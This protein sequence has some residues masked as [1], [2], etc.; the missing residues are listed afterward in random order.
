MHHGDTEITEKLFPDRLLLETDSLQLNRTLD[1]R[2]APQARSIAMSGK[3]SFYR[4]LRHFGSRGILLLS[5]AALLVSN[6]PGTAV[7]QGYERELSAPGRALLT[8][9]NR[10][11]RVS[12]IA[13]DSQKDKMT[14]QANSPGAPV[15]P[16]DVNVSGG[17]ITVRERRSQDRI[18]LTVHV[19]ARSRVKIESET[20]MVDVIGDFEVADVITNTGTIHADV[21]LDALKFKFLWQSSHPRFLSDVELP[22]IKEGRAGAFTIAGA[23]GPDAKRRKHKKK[24]ESDDSTTDD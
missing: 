1:R 13:S 18:D 20:G 21:P 15:E 23:V 10:D 11:G 16:G 12:V 4:R 24:A 9:K 5:A 19:P 6:L 2:A 22:P 3:P 17:E 7:A 8:I 14:L